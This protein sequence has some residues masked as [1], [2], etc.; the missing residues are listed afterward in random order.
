MS[1]PF[2]G[3]IKMFGGNFA[4]YQYALCNGQIMPIQQNQAL[5]T[6]LGTSFGGNGQTNFALP[7]LRG[8]A[9]MHTGQ[10]PGANN[11]NLGESGGT[12]STTMSVNQM[13]NHSHPI[14]VSTGGASADKGSSALMLAQSATS[15]LTPVN[16]YGAAST[17]VALAAQS[18]GAV[19]GN[20]PFSIQSPYLGINMIIALYGIFPSRN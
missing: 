16:I 9:P 20:L 1:E 3:E 19:G 11:I 7:D 10:S 18:C 2:V 14:M 17:N 15:D 8:R 5:F 4:P 13:P 12:P 6:I